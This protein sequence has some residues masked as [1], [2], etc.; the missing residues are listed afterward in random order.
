[1]TE[2]ASDILG[3]GD[4]EFEEMEE[5]EIQTSW[6]QLF[7][8]ITQIAEDE[9]ID[10]DETTSSGRIEINGDDTYEIRVNPAIHDLSGNLETL[11]LNLYHKGI[12]VQ[13]VIAKAKWEENNPEITDIDNDPIEGP[14]ESLGL[15]EIAT[16]AEVLL[17]RVSIDTDHAD[18]PKGAI[19]P[20][21][22]SSSE[23][24]N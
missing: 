12:H 9:Q 18:I 22:E 6:Q 3:V 5:D 23:L 24:P 20:L 14:F 1:M 2:R 8:L 19:F 10:V 11:S 7:L 15:I 16:C 13:Q 4:S 17:N 21:P